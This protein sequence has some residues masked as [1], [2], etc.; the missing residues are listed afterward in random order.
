MNDMEPWVLGGGGGLWARGEE[1][2][3]GAR[4]TDGALVG[5]DCRI[6]NLKLISIVCTWCLEGGVCGGSRRPQPS[7]EVRLAPVSTNSA[8]WRT[9]GWLRLAAVCNVVICGPLGVQ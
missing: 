3:P 5:T 2:T 6:C 4:A 8:S 7:P 1:L 9:R